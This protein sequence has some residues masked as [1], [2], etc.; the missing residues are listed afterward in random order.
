M[1][2]NID[3]FVNDVKLFT[4]GENDSISD[5]NKLLSDISEEDVDTLSL[6][7]V[8]DNEK[9]VYEDFDG[10][11]PDVGTELKNILVTEY[12]FKPT[13]VEANVDS[14]VLFNNPE[15]WEVELS[16]DE[17]LNEIAQ[18]LYEQAK[19]DNLVKSKESINDGVPNVGT[20]LK[21]ILV[22]KY[23]FKPSDVKASVDGVVLFSDPVNWT[24]ELSGDE[25]LDEIAQFLHEQAVAD[26]L[27]SE[28]KKIKESYVEDAPGEYTIWSAS[29]LA[30]EQIPLVKIKTDANGDLYVEAVGDTEFD[31]E[32]V[33]IATNSIA[34]S[35]K[36][37]KSLKDTLIRVDKS[38]NHS[39]PFFSVEFDRSIANSGMELI[40]AQA[41]RTLRDDLKAVANRKNVTEE[42]IVN[43]YTE[44]TGV[45]YYTDEIVDK[46]QYDQILILLTKDPRDKYNYISPKENQFVQKTK[47]LAE[48]LIEKVLLKNDPDFYKK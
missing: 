46:D 11:V 25:D 7:L 39:D 21:D 20:E 19:M 40:A 43:K 29:D 6:K 35:K 14:V 12:G 22:K 27:I 3:V 1:K 16:G 24:I 18:F 30:E 10:G 34:S 48:D 5:L 4:L 26:S 2:F 42:D 13:D 41:L 23:N 9:K 32:S 37:G 45:D 38:L 36:S 17:D 28:N 47:D 31:K 8:A 15:D 33:K 44:L